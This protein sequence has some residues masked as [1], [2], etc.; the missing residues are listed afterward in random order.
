MNTQ[1]FVKSIQNGSQDIVLHTKQAI[2]KTKKINNEY[3]FLTTLEEEKALKQAQSFEEPIEKKDESVKQKKLLGV[4]VTLKDAI[5]AYDIET[6]GCSDVLKGYKPLFDA[7]VV[8]RIKQAGG[9]ILGKTAQDEFGFGSFSVNIGKEFTIPKNPFDKERSCGGSSGGAAGF[10]QKVDFPHIA[11]G[12]STGGSIASPASFCGVFGLC[13][14][15]G[16]VSRYGLLDY[17]NSLDKIGPIAKSVY[18]LALMLEIIAG[19]DEK[20]ST[21]LT[22]PIDEYTSF[23]NKPVKGM[24]VGIIKEAFGEGTD[25]A[26]ENHVKAAIVKLKSEGVQCEEVSLPLTLKYGLATYYLIATSEASTNLAKYCGMRYGASEELSGS[27]NEFF[28]EVRSKYLGDEA[29]RRIILGTFARMSGYRDAYYIKAQKIRTKIINEYKEHFKQFDALLSPATPILP[30]R[31]DEVEKLTPLQHY[32]M[33]IPLVG[34]NLA[35]L[36][37]MSIPIGMEKKLPIGMLLVSDHLNESKLI[38]LA[39]VFDK[40]EA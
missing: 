8:K 12:E 34:P 25:K 22:Q 3:H 38:Q 27:F 21:T 31:F 4:T 10:T 30:P 19:V 5:C 24:K 11:L 33:D 37:H 32:K 13:P 14:T 7:T 23:V 40:K 17:A 36:P 1:S 18:D 26:V 2:E 28:T 29:K 9:I 15:Y 16:R 39:S 6:T 35:G 20:D